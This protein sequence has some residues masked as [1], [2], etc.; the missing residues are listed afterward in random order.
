LGTRAYSALARLS[1]YD[2]QW[3][4][5][6]IAAARLEFE[7]ED[8]FDVLTVL[9]RIEM[10]LDYERSEQLASLEIEALIL[11]ARDDFIVPFYH[12]EDLARRIGN[13]TLVEFEGGHFFPQVNPDI[14]ANRV[15]A[16]LKG[17]DI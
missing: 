12:S 7:G 1:G 14:F 2:A 4:E 15:A 11:G 10:L 9:G 8:Q 3:Y 13:S 17:G 16:F 5:Q 6:H